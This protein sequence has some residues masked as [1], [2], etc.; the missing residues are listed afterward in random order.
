MAKSACVASCLFL[1]VALTSG[2]ARSQEPALTRNPLFTVPAGQFQEKH[3]AL[4][5]GP[6]GDA[7]PV[8][9]TVHAGDWAKYDGF[10]FDSGVAGFRLES[11]TQNGLASLEIHL[12][13]PDGPLLG[14]IARLPRS[15]TP[16]NYLSASCKVDNSQAGV[17]DVYLVFGGD[18]AATT[19]VQFFVFQKSLRDQSNPPDLTKR[20]DL[21]NNDEPQATQAFGVPET[22]LTD[23]F[24]DLSHWKAQ[25][26]TV[27]SGAAVASGD[28]RAFTPDAYINKTDTGGDWRTLAQAALT[29]DITADDA[30]AKPALGF[31]SADG[32][33][34]ISVSLDFEAEVLRANRQLTGGPPQTIRTEPKLATDPART[35]HLKPGQPYRLRLAWSPYSNALM[36]FLS[37]PA[38]ATNK[39]LANFRTVIDLPAARR[40][41][42]LNAGGR[43]RFAHLVFDPAFDGWQP[44][45]QF[46]KTPALDL[47]DVC[48]PAVWKWTDGK[49]Y[50]VWRKFG[51]DTFHGIAT[52]D[53]AIHWTPVTDK[54]MKCTGDMN[55]LVDPLG[56]GK[57]YCTPGGANTP[58]F[59]SD[60]AD[61]FSHWETSDK[62]L[63]DI[64][65]F[66]R[67]QEIID[68]AKHSQLQPVQLGGKTYRFIAFVEDW[69]RAPKPHTGVM[70]SNT[71]TDWTLA[72]PDP[73]L[74]PRPDF[75]GEK[76]SAIGS[77]FVLPSGD[78][79]LASCS[80][81]AEGYTGAPEPTNVSVI[82]DGKQPWILKKLATLPDAPVSREN[83]W[84]QGPNFGT[85][86]LYE[87]ANDTLY[88]YGG[89]HDYS[90]GLMRLPNF[91]HPQPQNTPAK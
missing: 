90:I 19:A 28:A 10:D 74:P 17:R 70:L 79:L 73:L 20:L 52:S 50:M 36:A 80:C 64:H 47:K 44:R 33:Q 23:D 45:W 38:D 15:N 3:G 39:P 53:D 46:L 66:S 59:T 87:P 5:P 81:T 68:T 76:G 84:Y 24:H 32:Q 56:D 89:F 12:D 78:I 49:D 91:L 14:K 30:T 9:S 63:G 82:V 72:S 65:G 22:G 54:V 35:F 21:P 6:A 88:F 51:A 41:L 69:T 34:S 13:K 57:V 55:V 8:L 75:W 2:I 60:G 43:A 67:I 4:H 40:P 27:S 11:S 1:T 61:H 42:L 37:K 48:N 58:W 31:A 7:G 71:L 86:F 29:A 26:F 85:A 16:D 77:A 62:K 18:S 83:V 25:G